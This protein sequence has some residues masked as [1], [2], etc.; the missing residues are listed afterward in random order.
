MVVAQSWRRFL[1]EW[2]AM[3]HY[4]MPYALIIDLTFRNPLIEHMLPALLHV[5]ALAVLDEAL[6]A[7]ILDHKLQ[8][9]KQSHKTLAGRI[10]FL[11][12]SKVLENGPALCA[13]VK[14]RNEVA[15]ELRASLGWD[16]LSADVDAVEA[17]LKRLGYVGS[18]PK[19]EYFGERSGFEG[20]NEPGVL[21]IRQFRIG[22]KEEGSPVY[23]ASWEQ[24]LHG[25][26][27]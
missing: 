20:S 26:G 3:K 8:M 10:R 27:G 21:G 6:K 1:M 4:H 2:E 5:K 19:M 12:D 23:E 24:K 22:V 25:A 17:A 15:H 18:R 7:Y 13:A 16:A 9:P 14:R 11:A